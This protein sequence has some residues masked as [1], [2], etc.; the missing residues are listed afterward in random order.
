LTV[1]PRARSHTRARTHARGAVREHEKY[2]SLATC[3]NV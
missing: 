3:C 2:V 1:K